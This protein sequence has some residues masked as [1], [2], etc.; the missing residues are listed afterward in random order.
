MPQAVAVPNPEAEKRELNIVLG[1]YAVFFVVQGAIV[2]LLHVHPKPT[3]LA[4]L[5]LA[6]VYPVVLA[7]E[8]RV[9]PFVLAWLAFVGSAMAIVA[10]ASREGNALAARWIFGYF[11]VVHR[12]SF[13]VGVLGACGVFGFVVAVLF[14]QILVRLL[15]YSALSIITGAYVGVV[16]RD[17][18]VVC[19]DRMQVRTS[20]FKALANM[21]VVCGGPLRDLETRKDAAGRVWQIEE[22]GH[23]LHE[24]CA[25]GWSLIGKRHTSPCCGEVMATRWIDATNPWQRGR[26][27]DVRF[28]GSRCLLTLP[29]RGA[30]SLTCSG[31]ASCSRPSSCCCTEGFTLDPC[32]E[33]A[34]CKLRLVYHEKARLLGEHFFTHKSTSKT[35]SQVRSMTSAVAGLSRLACCIAASSPSSS[36]LSS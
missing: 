27:S 5:A 16:Q 13:G 7:V 1:A 31:S 34:V 25:R 28:L 6:L 15:N 36:S 8:L 35:A 14:D 21:C 12:L 9:V 30:M 26:A 23:E 33:Y 19:R 24:E 20:R 17:F 10:L 11:A 2:V 32:F 3:R 29:R 4:L 22:C 18:A